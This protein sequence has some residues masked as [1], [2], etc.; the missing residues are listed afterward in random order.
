MSDTTKPAR[1]SRSGFNAPGV[2]AD[3]ARNIVTIEGAT[4]IRQDGPYVVK[5]EESEAESRALTPAQEVL[6]DVL[7][8]VERQ[9]EKWGE[10][11]HPLVGGMSALNARRV[12]AGRARDWKGINDDRVARKQMGW[13]SILLE[14]VY[15]ALELSD[16]AEARV[17]WVQVA[18]VA[19][20]AILCIDRS[21]AKD[22]A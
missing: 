11:N 21:L 17:E 6:L 9:D 5:G 20:N 3:E 16:P 12:Y 8:E 19:A 15:E 7:A 1:T 2:T 10:Q 13:D 18:A 14:E 22:A 4:F